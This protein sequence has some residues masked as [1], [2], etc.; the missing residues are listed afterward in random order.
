MT[1]ILVIGSAIPQ[2][3]LKLSLEKD[4]EHSDEFNVS[5]ILIHL[6]LLHSSLL[7][8]LYP[9]Y[10]SHP[11][12]ASTVCK[13]LMQFQ[14]QVQ[15]LSEVCAE[16]TMMGLPCIGVLRNSLGNDF[17]TAGMVYIHVV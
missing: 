8:L 14:L 15:I 5:F 10:T 3:R 13:M 4:R 11:N 9:V 6:H 16:A 1:L 12:H 7:D 17:T 2:T